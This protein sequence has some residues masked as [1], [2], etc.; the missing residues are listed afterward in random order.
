MTTRCSMIQMKRLL[1]GA[2]LLAG[3]LTA[4]YSREGISAQ[5]GA[6]PAASPFIV[7]PYLQLGDVPKLSPVETLRVL[8]QAPN[9]PGATWSVDVRQDGGEAWRP[10][11]GAGGR[12]IPHAEAPYRLFSV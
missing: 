9:E 6:S 12:L 4:A 10:A 2:S 7:E 1:V 8:W 5:T 3:V 11:V